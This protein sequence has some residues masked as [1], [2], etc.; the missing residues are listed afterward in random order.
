MKKLFT[1]D[2]GA[3][4]SDEQNL[5][6]AIERKSVVMQDAYLMEERSYFNREQASKVAMHAKGSCE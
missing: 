2:L 3:S 5:I 6:S 4:L 1:I